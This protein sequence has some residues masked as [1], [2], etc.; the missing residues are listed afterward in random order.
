VIDLFQKY[1]FDECG[2]QKEDKILVALSGGPDS[3]LLLHLLKEV[4]LEISAAHCNFGLRGIESDED[5]KFVVELCEYHHIP[6]HV[7]D[8]NLSNA[9][10]NIQMK[11]RDLRYSWFSALAEKEQLD[12][13]AIGSQLDDRL[14]TALINMLRGTGPAG[15]RNMQARTEKII[16][17]FLWASKQ[18]ILE[19]IKLRKI[20]F[21][22]DSSNEKTD[23]LRNSLRLEVVP[24]LKKL[25]PKLLDNYERSA[26]I[27][28]SYEEVFKHSTQEFLDEHLSSVANNTILKIS[29]LQSYVSPSG[30]LFTWLTPF[31]FNSEQLSEIEKAIESTELQ[32]FKTETHLLHV[33]RSELCLKEHGQKAISSE[34]ITSFPHRSSNF[35]LDL[36]LIKKPLNLKAN[37]ALFLDS[38]KL[39]LPLVLRPWNHGDK[40][41]PLGMS[42]NKKVSDI[43]TD[44][45]LASHI[46]DRQAVLLSGNKICALP[47]YVVSE[48]FKLDDKS[49][50]CLKITLFQAAS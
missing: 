14:E 21:R 36:S 9:K 48:E 33:D 20:S 44:M 47:P 5:E 7:A 39:S 31:G 49:L 13:I 45:K 18:E 15:F 38:S 40:M 6:C 26:R 32:K 25:Q 42:G 22:K 50:D 8:F 1:L 46:K 24:L 10:G 30:L 17:P 2:V 12:L 19:E 29:D 11:A 16:R 41:I 4:G 34:E 27:M 23:Y 35:Q 3:V 28:Q 43:L 37:N